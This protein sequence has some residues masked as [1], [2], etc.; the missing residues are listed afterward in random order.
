M[1]PAP[2]QPLH[3]SMQPI[4]AGGQKDHSQQ[5]EPAQPQAPVDVY[6]CIYREEGSRLES[7]FPFQRTPASWLVVAFS[8][9]LSNS[10]RGRKI[11]PQSFL[12]PNLN[13]SPPTR[14]H[15]LPCL[16]AEMA[17][18]SEA[19]HQNP[20]CFWASSEVPFPPAPAAPEASPP[21]H[22]LHTSLSPITS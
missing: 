12:I 11:Y 4:Q 16:I 21:S 17:H 22:E 18:P 6:T 2:L 8:D 1:D 15:A 5:Q 14:V 13:T 19:S 3:S 20:C 10:F 7:P 9:F